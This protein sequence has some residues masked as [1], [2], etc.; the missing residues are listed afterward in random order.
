[1]TLFEK[2]GAPDWGPEGQLLGQLV[3][4][5]QAVVRQLLGRCGLRS[6]PLIGL[7]FVLG[8]LWQASKPPQGC[9]SQGQGQRRGTCF[10]IK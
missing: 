7:G 5:A 6:T 2:G 4:A 1:M 8:D 9:H 3:V 10:S